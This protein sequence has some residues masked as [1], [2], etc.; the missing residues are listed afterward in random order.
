MVALK[1]LDFKV[2]ILDDSKSPLSAYL[3]LRVQISS[4]LALVVTSRGQV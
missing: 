2:P 1:G 4:L 3:E